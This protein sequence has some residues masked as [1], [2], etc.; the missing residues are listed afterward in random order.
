MKKRKKEHSYLDVCLSLFSVPT[1]ERST[2]EANCL[3]EKLPLATG[4]SI[5]PLFL[6]V[7]FDVA[8]F[9][10]METYVGKICKNV[11]NQYPIVISPGSTALDAT[12]ESKSGAFPLPPR[13]VGRKVNLKV[14]YFIFLLFPGIRTCSSSPNVSVTSWLSLSLGHW[15]VSVVGK[16]GIQKLHIRENDL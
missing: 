7:F 15:D 8:E 2:F 6:R 3:E 1:D 4:T 11:C 13:P 12:G 5:S 9:V 14:T 10:L 16:K